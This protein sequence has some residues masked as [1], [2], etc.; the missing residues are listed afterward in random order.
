MKM[1]Y[2][3][4]IAAAMPLAA[5]AQGIPLPA[6]PQDAMKDAVIE[7]KDGTRIVHNANGTMFHANEKGQRLSMTGKMEAKDGSVY[8][9]RNGYVWKLIARGERPHNPN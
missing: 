2:A 9:M 1:L 6:V 5:Y 4:A 3:L 7:L 8:W